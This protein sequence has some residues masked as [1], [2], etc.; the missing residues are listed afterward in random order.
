[1]KR[2]FIHANVN[3]Q[4]LMLIVMTLRQEDQLKTLAQDHE[5]IIHMGTGQ[6]GV[7]QELLQLS[8]QWHSEIKS[9]PLRHVLAKHLISTIH[10][11]LMA[12]Q[13]CK[14]GSEPWKEFVKASLILENGDLPYLQWDAQSQSLIPSKEKPLS[15]KE[16]KVMVEELHGRTTL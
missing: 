5:F 13:E 6:G 11:R 2:N 9:A 8:Q 3:V 10:T 16:V 14:K 7:M 12:L 1:M 15:L 4:L